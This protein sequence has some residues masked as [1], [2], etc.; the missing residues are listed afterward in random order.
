MRRWRKQNERQLLLMVL[1]VLVLVGGGLIGLIFGWGAL[2]TSL[3]C[4][5]G[6]AVTI[7]A[8][9]LLLTLIERRMNL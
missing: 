6:G 9:Y 3:P 8:L 7:V 4:L 1:F 2:L 5:L